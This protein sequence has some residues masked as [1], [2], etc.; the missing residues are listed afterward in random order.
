MEKTLQLILDYLIE[1]LKATGLQLFILL[2]PLLIL[3]FAMH[4]VA[5]RIRDLGLSVFGYKTFIYSFKSI[6][7]PLHEM[8]HALFAVLFGHK[9]TDIKL[10]DP[11]A[12]D[13]SFG[14]VRHSHRP[15]N[16]YNEIGTFFIGIGPILM[17][18]MMLYAITWIMFRFSVSDV[19]G[20]NITSEHL[21]NSFSLKQT[22]LGILQ[23]F[24][25]FWYIVFH[26]NHSSWWK[27]IIFIYLLFSIGSSITLSPPDIEGAVSGLLFFVVLLV[28]FNLLTLWIGNF[29]VSALAQANS[30][31]SGFYFIMAIA[32]LT[33][34]V[35]ALLLWGLKPIVWEIRRKINRY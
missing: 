9:I 28:V 19:S 18:T 14:Y 16:I 24:Q 17:C 35:F 2:G 31:F 30:F 23:G 32:L 27:I 29:T 11:D 33:N 7:T 25:Q 26:G 5:G 8:G 12:N 21:L 34:I 20:I 3:S 10:F 1:V 22:G 4:F 15:G 13:G 6:G